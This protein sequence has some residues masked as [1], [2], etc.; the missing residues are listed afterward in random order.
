MLF[1]A[2]VVCI[3]S[4][5]GGGGDAD[6]GTQIVQGCDDFY[7]HKVFFDY[8]PRP[9]ACGRDAGI[10]AIANRSRRPTYRW[11]CSLDGTGAITIFRKC[12]I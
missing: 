6:G 11:L 8:S 7:S 5:V 10:R 3:V 1:G 12:L 2:F 9:R 4:V